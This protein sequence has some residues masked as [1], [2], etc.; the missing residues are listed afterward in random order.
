MT[1]EIKRVKHED[2]D[3]IYPEGEDD[4]ISKFTHAKRHWPQ[5]MHQ[6]PWAVDEQL[7]VFLLKLPIMRD[8]TSR[9][10]LFGM[11]GG[12][13]LIRQESYSTYS[14]LYVSPSLTSRIEEVKSRIREILRMAGEAIDGTTDEKSSF[15]V[16]N[17]KFKEIN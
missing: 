11:S 4:A 9:R 2:L 8:D 15:S 7:G 6:M 17:A 3:R 13:A 14:F 5:D 16:P 10:Y 12:V 1:Y